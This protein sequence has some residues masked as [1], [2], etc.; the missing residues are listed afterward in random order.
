MSATIERPPFSTSSSK[1]EQAAQDFSDR[2][3]WIGWAGWIAKGT[4]YALIG[5]LFLRIAWLGGSDEEANQKGAIE[6]VADNAFGT[7]LLVVLAAGLAL[8]V[9]WRLLTV[10]LPGDW[11]GRALLDR[12]GYAVSAVTYVT[13]LVSIVDVIG[14]SASASG[15]EGEDRL[16]EGLVKDTLSMTAGRWLVALAGVVVIGIGVAFVHKGWTKSFRDD[17]SG[18][19]G[20]EGT[21]VDRLGIVGWIARGA[22]MIV[23]GWFLGL[24]AYRFDADEAAG[25][26]DSIRQLTET[27]W[28]SA[29]AIAIAI[30]FMAFGA[31]CIVSARHRDLLGP[32]ND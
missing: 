1:A 14:S 10:V 6:E 17:I 29:I 8:Y 18:D 31:F 4:V 9:L 23:I 5:L 21:L 15:D 22:V 12:I 26:D 32:R 27:G 11:T 24:A 30:G 25:F 16:I 7:T 2:F 3:E 20:L 19:Y 13:V 28:G